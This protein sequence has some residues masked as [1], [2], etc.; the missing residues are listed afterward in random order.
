MRL[1]RYLISRTLPLL[2]EE[3]SRQLSAFSKGL[4]AIFLANF[5]HNLRRKS[6]SNPGIPTFLASQLL[7]EAKQPEDNY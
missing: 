5:T 7:K 2:G 6:S 4:R 1:S 3:G